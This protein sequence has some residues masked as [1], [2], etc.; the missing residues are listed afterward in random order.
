MRGEGLRR[1]AGVLGVPGGTLAAP[2]HENSDR[3]RVYDGAAPDG[4]HTRIPEPQAGVRPVNRPVRAAHSLSRKLNTAEQLAKVIE[5]KLLHG[6]K[7]P[8][9]ATSEW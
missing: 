6:A 9:A 4:E 2:A 3:E 8:S 7:R 1:A 5:G